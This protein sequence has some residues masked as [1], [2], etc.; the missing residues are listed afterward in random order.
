MPSCWLRRLAAVVGSHGGFDL[1]GESEAARQLRSRG[2]TRTHDIRAD[3]PMRMPDKWH[4]AIL[5]NTAGAEAEWKDKVTAAVK[6]ADS[7]A[8]SA[9][10]YGSKGRTA[11]AGGKVIGTAKATLQYTVPHNQKVK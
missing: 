7:L 4:G 3:G 5:G 1:K 2:L 8:T 11:Q 9:M 6:R 10:P